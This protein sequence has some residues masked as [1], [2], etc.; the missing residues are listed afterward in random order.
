M[1]PKGTKRAKKNEAWSWWDEVDILEANQ[2]GGARKWKCRYCG[3]TKHGG[4]NRVQG[5]LIHEPGQEIQPCLSISAEK[6]RELE[7]RHNEVIF[8]APPP[9]AMAANPSFFTTPSSNFS[10][11]VGSSSVHQPPPPK[12]T[13]RTFTGSWNPREREAVDAAIARFFYH[14]HIAFNVARSPYFQEMVR[15][16]AEFGPTYTPPSS[17]SLRTTL[18]AKE[19]ET[20]EQAMQ[21]VKEGWQRNGVSIISDGWSDSQSRSIHGII[22]YSRGNTFFV[23]SHDASPTG[24]YADVIVEEWAEAIDKWVL[25]M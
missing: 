1:P 22:A 25:K 17:E 2:G 21:N 18:L 8:R 7:A 16:I 4:V 15:L 13:Q 20:V 14:D 10:T 6:K 3:S 12:G 5:H 9:R 23:S 24:K 19:K 11:S